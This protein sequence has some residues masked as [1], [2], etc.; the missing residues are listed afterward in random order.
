MESAEEEKE[1]PVAVVVGTEELPL[2]VVVVDW[3]EVVD[4]DVVDEVE[5][6]VEAG[7]VDAGAFVIL[8]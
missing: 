1:R 2:L 7:E 4:E 6:L 5:V 8:K 3:D